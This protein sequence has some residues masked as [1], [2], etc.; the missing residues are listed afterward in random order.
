[1]TYEVKNRGDARQATMKME[2]PATAII[3]IT[4]IGR[5]KNHFHKQDWLKGVLELQFNDVMR[6]KGCIT[7]KQAEEIADFVFNI[8]PHVERILVHCEYGQSRSAGVAAAI[9]Q[10][11]EGNSSGIF[12]NPAYY[13]NRTCFDFVLEALKNKKKKKRRWLWI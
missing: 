4:D 7:K 9:S 10:H 3:S 12:G 11:Y 8:Y 13:P 6:G 5:D 2:A 1:M